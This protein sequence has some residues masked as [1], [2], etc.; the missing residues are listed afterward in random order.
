MVSGQR[1]RNKA[2]F[3]A[4]GLVWVALMNGLALAGARIQTES[5]GKTGGSTDSPTSYRMV[6][7]YVNHIQRTNGVDF[8]CTN[9]M[10][11]LDILQ[12]DVLRIRMN[13]SGH[14]LA[15]EPWVV[16]RYEWPVIPFGLEDKGAYLALSTRRL[17]VK[18][19]KEPFRLEMCDRGGR[20][21][22]RDCPEGGMG[23]RD[24]EVIC[25]KVLTPTDHFFGLGQRFEKSDLRGTKTTCLVTRE[26]TPVPFFMGSDGYGIF[27]HNFHISAFDFTHDPYS[28]SAP[29]GELDYYFIYGP[30]FKHILDRYTEITGKS[31][32]PPKWAFGLY[33]SRWNGD[34]GNW[35]YRQRG[36]EG[37]LRTMQAVREVW[38]WPLDGIRISP[39]GPKQNFYASPNTQWPEAA[40]GAFPAVDQL[41]KQLHGLH[42][43]P[44]FW[45]TPGVFEG[46][47]MYDEGVAN[48]YFLTRD[49]KPVNLEFAFVSP[50]GGLVDF[51]NPAARKWWGK[52]HHFM[53]DFGSDG[54]AGD[55]SEVNAR[56]D[57]I[58]P[59]TGMQ[60][61]DFVNI[62]S[63]LFNQASWD[64]YRERN[65][66]KRCIAFG[67]TYWAGGQR[68]PMQGSQDSHLGGK[69]IWGE[70]MGTINLGLSGIP[71]RTYTDNVSSKLFPNSPFSRLSQFLCVTVAGE[72]TQIVVT[73]IPMADWNYRF[74]GKLR[75]RLMPY[76]YTYARETTQTG[77]PLV[78]ALVLE[79]QTD[80]RAYDAFGEYLLGRDLL[81][82]PLWSDTEFQREIYLPEGEW[83]DF[84]DETLY[85]GGRTITYR[86]PI[87]RVPI[88]V[89]N[90]A[91]IPLAPE[92]QHYVDERKSPYT[93]HVYP[94]GT[95]SFD[96][97]DDDG[98]SYDYERGVYAITKYSYREHAN[99][100]TIEKSIPKGKYQI[101]E[102]EHLFCVHGLSRVQSV[103]QEGDLL[104]PLGSDEELNAAQVGCRWD[105]P[106]KRLWIKV[107][108]GVKEAMTLQID[109]SRSR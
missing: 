82:A 31:P 54:I 48:N 38:D 92:D 98:E 15:N 51:L 79:Y 3:Y 52:Y 55:W 63:L 85:S 81:I 20:V 53:V 84:L 94:K 86:A 61:E 71:F 74:Y 77:I 43:H 64:A 106:G 17:L 99:G 83:V 28:F 100:L 23:Y 37:I 65:P 102:R 14:F 16:I 104:K 91:I 90:G 42:I 29:G 41:V 72:R 56:G 47:K 60:A 40:W 26:Y 22:S 45:E 8:R 32:L 89:R 70:M 18:V 5:N 95:G 44:L 12:K 50:P 11:R 69:N 68:Y 4:V 2:S 67:L 76:I 108:G 58:S 80:P 19:F 105:E 13:P 39:F 34:S 25:K 49:G 103:R 93:I 87:D 59:F 96:L 24:D 73:G 66:D 62:Y 97:Y 109:F 88:L 9:A 6:G 7:K 33:H 35:D 1:G 107:K 75:Y 30:E 78:R 27:F 57:M 21:I 36:Q 10:V 101:P 46:C